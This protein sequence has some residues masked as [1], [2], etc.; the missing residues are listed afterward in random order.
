MFLRDFGLWL[1][2]L[3]NIT[4]VNNVSQLWSPVG[5][6]KIWI[7]GTQ[8]S[9]GNRNFWNVFPEN[10]RCA[11]SGLQFMICLIT[12]CQREFRLFADGKWLLYY[13]RNVITTSTIGH[14]AHSA[15]EPI[16]VAVT[17]DKWPASY[18]KWV[19]M[20]IS[21]GEAGSV[22]VTN[23]L[24]L[25]TTVFEQSSLAPKAQAKNLKHKV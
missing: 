9:L 18:F 10:F 20:K 14:T 1:M 17:Y 11:A 16:K 5:D 2:F 13:S 3:R 19:L 6:Q 24:W 4:N 23:Y 25:F 12:V 8:F 15:S 22:A 7:N 21:E